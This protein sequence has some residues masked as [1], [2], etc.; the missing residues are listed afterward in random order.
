MAR[1]EFANE[2]RTR[3]ACDEEIY[4]AE[5]VFGE[6]IGNVTRHAMG[7]VEAIVDWDGPAPVLHIRDHGPG[8]QHAPRLP[9]DVLS[10]NGRGLYIV[11]ALTSDFNV[12]RMPGQGSHARAVIALSRYHLEQ[13]VT[14]V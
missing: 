10:E 1:V 7:E 9:S 11:A 6:L 12:T 3:S 13:P 2:L 8:F 5:I 4:A 14:L